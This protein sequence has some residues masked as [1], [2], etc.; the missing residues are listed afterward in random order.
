MGSFWSLAQSRSCV[1]RPLSRSVVCFRLQSAKA[2]LYLHTIP[3]CPPAHPSVCI[4]CWVQLLKAAIVIHLRWQCALGQWF[5][6]TFSDAGQCGHFLAIL[7]FSALLAAFGRTWPFLAP[8]EIFATFGHIWPFWVVML[9]VWPPLDPYS[10]HFFCLFDHFWHFGCFL[11]FWTIF[12]HFGGGAF[13][14]CHFKQVL[15]FFGH[16]W[17]ILTIFD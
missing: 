9:P 3:D 17:S 8:L 1:H 12:S 11:L 14:F 4:Y 10:G 16:F 6:S 13:F 5:P 2:P 15:A 7:H